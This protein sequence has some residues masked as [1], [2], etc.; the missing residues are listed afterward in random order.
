MNADAPSIDSTRIAELATGATA[1]ELERREKV[2]HVENLAVAYSGNV[3]LRDVA[4]DVYE[5]TVTAFIE[6]NRAAG[7]AQLI[8]LVGRIALHTVDQRLK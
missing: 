6:P 7:A 8:D 3:A 4:L 5:N 2:F 1:E